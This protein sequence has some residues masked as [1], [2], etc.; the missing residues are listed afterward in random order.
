[1]TDFG[2]EE[3]FGAAAMRMKEHHGVDINESA[4]RKITQFHAG[5][6]QYFAT[7]FET[8][9]RPVEQMILELDGEMVPLVEYKGGP[10]KRKNKVLLWSELRV[11]TAQCHEELD[12]RY[13]VSFGKADDLGDK[14]GKIMNKMGKEEK[15]N[16]HGVGDGAKW[17]PEQGERIA[18]C[19]YTHLIDLY[20]LCEYFAKAV[21]GWTED[22]KK[23]IK[24]FKDYF[25]KGNG[26]EG[27]KILKEQYVKFP[28]HE[29]LRKC[30][31][32]IENRPGQFEYKKAK[33]LGL[34]L[35]SG[36]VESTHRSL[37]Q[38]RLKKPG[39]WWLRENASKMADLRVVRAN[40][41]WELL[42]QENYQDFCQERAA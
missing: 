20:H 2:V 39:S 37:I 22:P 42:W 13:G 40:N 26:I 29:G 33:Q 30:I 27:L 5:R 7:E 23:E 11:G 38:K 31:Q 32:Y 16:V 3:S 24:R 36:K 1:M 14:M 28:K 18:G 34:P 12:W 15:T 21:E 35:G 17:I 25:K 8:R 6:A 9:K 41:C 10:D 4:I 19:K